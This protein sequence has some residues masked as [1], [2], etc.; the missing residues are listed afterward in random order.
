LEYSLNK[1][2]TGF[3]AGQTR[4]TWHA[5][6]DGKQRNHRCSSHPVTCRSL[7]VFPDGCMALLTR[8]LSMDRGLGI[9]IKVNCPQHL[10]GWGARQYP[11]VAIITITERISNLNKVPK[12]NEP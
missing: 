8:S 10:P 11:S 4:L 1:I 7:T 9:E 12:G 2:W 6:Q 5:K 3:T